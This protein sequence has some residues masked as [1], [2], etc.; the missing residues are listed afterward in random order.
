MCEP[1]SIPINPYINNGNYDEFV[2]NMK[3]RSNYDYGFDVVNGKTITLS[4]CD[5]TGKSRIIVHAFN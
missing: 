4:T 2:N 3:Q 1:D 5:S